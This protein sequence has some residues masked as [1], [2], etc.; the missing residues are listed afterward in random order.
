MLIKYWLQIQESSNV[1]DEDNLIT[2]NM[3]L[4]IAL[5]FGSNLM[6]EGFVGS[7]TV[8]S[9]VFPVLVNPLCSC[10]AIWDQVKSPFEFCT[11]HTSL[12]TA[13]LPTH[14]VN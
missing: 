10:T 12:T 6:L 2:L 1:P 5:P 8:S 7:G 4:N 13:V 9:S 11:K 3:S 14:M